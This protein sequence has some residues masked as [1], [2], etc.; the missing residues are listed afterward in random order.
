MQIIPRSYSDLCAK[1]TM[2][3]QWSGDCSES[4]D[5]DQKCRGW[6]TFE[7]LEGVSSKFRTC[8]AEADSAKW[9]AKL[10]TN[11]TTEK[12]DLTSN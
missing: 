10:Q 12:G 6:Y 8:N 7:E 2:D 5:D 4:W 9:S 3:K 11:G 1:A